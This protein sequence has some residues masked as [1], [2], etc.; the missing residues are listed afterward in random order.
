M[1]LFKTVLFPSSDNEFHLWLHS[2]GESAAVTLYVCSF[3]GSYSNQEV[4]ATELHCFS[5]KAAMWTHHCCNGSTMFF[6]RKYS[7]T[8]LS[9]RRH[10]KTEAGW[11]STKSST[12]CNR[13][14]SFH[15][16]SGND[17]SVLNKLVRPCFC[18]IIPFKCHWKWHF[19]HCME[20]CYAHFFKE[21]L[22]K[23]I[24]LFFF[25]D[26]YLYSRHNS[27]F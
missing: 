5:M 16:I 15:W 10:K 17:S 18:Y 26:V 12:G 14:V 8:H 25:T 27:I 23:C 20:L 13:R 2:E 9:V 19:A 22:H 4:K 6:H 3:S 11:F 21:I 7:D 1:H 24:Y